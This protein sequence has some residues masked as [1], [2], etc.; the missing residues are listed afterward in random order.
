MNLIPKILHHIWVGPKQ[1]PLHWMKTWVD[2]HPD[3]EYML[4]SNHELN[5]MEFKNRELIDLF[6]KYG[7]YDGVADLMRYEILYNYGGFMPGTDA[8]CLTPIDDLL[9]NRA[10]TV[11]ENEKLANHRTSPILGA[12]KNYPFLKLLTD[13][14]YETVEDVKVGMANHNPPVLVGNWV[15]GDLI[16][17]YNPNG[18][19]IL[20]SNAL[21]GTYWDGTNGYNSSKKIYKR[22]AI[23]HWGMGRGMY[24]G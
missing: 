15:V 22:Y 3:W 21:I 17:K 18:L 10:I 20:P 5:T 12:E 2:K 23:Q 11:Y 16:R 1:M 24:N 9:D 4:W 6:Y 14:F 8:E 7:K 13:Y 19:L